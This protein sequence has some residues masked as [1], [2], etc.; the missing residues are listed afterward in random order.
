MSCA[1][2]LSRLAYSLAVRLEWDQRCSGRIGQEPH[3]LG[4]KEWEMESR[5]VAHH[6]HWLLFSHVYNILPIKSTLK[7]KTAPNFVQYLISYI[8][9]SRSHWP[10]SH[11]NI[12]GPFSP[13][14]LITLN[15]QSATREAC[16]WQSM[17]KKKEEHGCVSIISLC[18][19]PWTRPG[20]I[21]VD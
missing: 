9:A 21:A 15:C 13:S 18:R 10:S 11:S 20:L 4:N 16:G 5:F 12:E 1:Y 19:S 2:L 3:Y 8:T 6:Q 17:W 7:V 14:Q